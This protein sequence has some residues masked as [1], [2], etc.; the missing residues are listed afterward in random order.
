MAEL[1]AFIAFDVA[2]TMV[3]ASPLH[4]ATFDRITN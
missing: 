2:E 1:L 4:T 3:G